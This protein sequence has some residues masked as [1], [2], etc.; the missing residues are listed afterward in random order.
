MI[1]LFALRQT[2]PDQMVKHPA[3]VGPENDAVTRRVL[4]ECK[5]A[6]LPVIAGRG[7]D[8]DHLG[9]HDQ[10]L[11]IADEVGID[12]Y[13]FDETAGGFPTHPLYLGYAKK[14]RLWRRAAT[15]P[16]PV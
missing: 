8:G 15:S 11:D 12:L 10:A 5:A 3:P 6:G 1:N 16:C 14:P 2:Y 4:A 9:R 7:V 13:C